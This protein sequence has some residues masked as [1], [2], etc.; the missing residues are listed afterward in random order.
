MNASG[1]ST[2]IQT[3]AKGSS[4]LEEAG[5]RRTF[6]IISHPDAGKTTL[7]EKLLL[8]GQALNEAGSVQGRQ[9][10]KATTS[11]WMDLEQRRGIS[12]S[13]TVLRFEHKGTV[14]N[15]LDTPGHSDFSE[16]TLR[17]MSAVDSAVI[18]IDAAKGI[19]SQTLRLFE[20][21]RSRGIPLITFIN[22][23][24]RPGIEPLELLDH[25]ESTLDLLPTALTWPVGEP[26]DLKG[27]VDL[28]ER[29]FHQFERSAPGGLAAA[30]ETIV[31]LDSAPDGSAAWNI[32]DEELSLL[33]AAGHEFDPGAVAEGIST[34]ILFGSALTNF[35]VELLLDTIIELAP[36][37]G[38]RVDL[39]ERPRELDGDFSGLVFK[40]QANM[41]PRHRD[42]NAFIRICS[43][44]FDRGMKVINARTGRP[45]SLNYASGTFGRQRETIEEAFP[46]DIVGVVGAADLH[47]GDTVY[48]GQELRFPPL[49][50]LA[51]EQ[52]IR[53]RNA[54]ARKHKQFTRA[55][56]QLAEEGVIH[57]L[58]QDG[59]RDPMPLLGGV[60]RLQV[61]VATE[62]METEFN[63]Q[64]KVDETDWKLARRTDEESA[65]EMREGRLAELRTRS[66]GVLFALVTSQ[67]QHDRLVRDKPHLTLDHMV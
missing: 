29:N 5:R 36:P 32:A 65:R 19:E 27:I 37:P 63:V 11:D 26:G 33:E 67:F 42:R 1:P 57:V 22:K 2:S 50:T 48:Q 12:V 45:L 41:D 17:V 54:D 4:L 53:V 61:E 40:V 56:D 49:P 60:G 15:L 46:G 38:P 31:D 18:L 66:D 20:V 14:I 62:R 64:V 58:T 6:A 34:P 55:L 21:A 9:K 24:D 30:S 10:R 23:C 44:K 35:G 13:S 28:R 47:V 43:G 39:D 3:A 59:G 16:D 52:F 51:P 25:I 7:T 8:Y